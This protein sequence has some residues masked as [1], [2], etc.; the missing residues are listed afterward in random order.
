M[1]NKPLINI[2]YISSVVATFICIFLLIALRAN[3]IISYHEGWCTFYYDSHYVCD[4]ISSYE[5]ICRLTRGF[6]LQ[7]FAHP[8]HG[9]LVF[10][11][12]FAITSSIITKVMDKAMPVIKSKIVNGIISAIAG[13]VI[14][15]ILALCTIGNLCHISATSI[16]HTSSQNQIINIQYMKAN[17]Y[18]RNS[19]WDNVINVC[20]E[21]SPV[22]FQPLQNCL[23]I[24]LAEK[25]E[26]GDRLFEEPCGDI[27]SIMT[28]QISNEYIAALLSDVYYSMGHIAQ[29]Q[30]Y[31]FEAN[32]KMDNLSPRMLQRLVQTNIIYGHY[33]V[34]EKYLYYLEHTLYYG[35][36]CAEQRNLIREASS[37]KENEWLREKRKCLIK[38]NRFSGIHG[39]DD[40]L[41]HIIASARGT[42]QGNTTL[43]FLGSLYILAGY[44][45]QFEEMINDYKD[46]L[47][48]PLPKYFDKYS[49][50]I[51]SSEA[52][53]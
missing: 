8:W 49:K 16:I 2:I 19:D 9:A 50:L 21:N 10:A 34:A 53:E 5:G 18:S 27:G 23:N 14:S 32:E 1:K 20:K 39:L 44:N 28:N 33:N 46:D 42:H 12:L 48:S 41:R 38:D 30:R 22:S 17:H 47:G 29:A 36:W 6:F 4:N 35:G 31:A 7:F 26:L 25:G 51:T 37:G 15:I 11:I 52:N 3:E 43:Q 13:C 40:D 24:A 45:I